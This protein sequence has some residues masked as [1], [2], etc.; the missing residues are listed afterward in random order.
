MA[1]R[2]NEDTSFMVNRS[3]SRL[4]LAAALLLAP[5]LTPGVLAQGG[6]TAPSRYEGLFG[7]ERVA[8]TSTQGLDLA[9]SIF[10]GYDDNLTAGATN[11]QPRQALLLD[12]FYSGLQSSLA[13]GKRWGTAAEFTAG[14]GSFVRHYPDLHAIT[15]MQHR[16]AVSFTAGLGSRARLNVRQ[17]V[18]YTPRYQFDPF[19]ELSGTLAPPAALAEGQ[20][21]IANNPMLVTRTVASLSQDLTSRTS[22]DATYGIRDAELR[23]TGR[24]FRH[25]YAGF[26]FG[27][28][29]TRYATLRLGYRYT[30]AG[31]SD[32][33]AQITHAP[34]VGIAYDRPLSFSRRTSVSFGGGSAIHGSGPTIDS[35]SPRYRV[36]GFAQVTRDVGRSWVSRLAYSRGVLYLE[37]YPQPF[38]SDSVVASV[39]G[40]LSPRWDLV[41]QA[42]YVRGTPHTI[43]P[44]PDR[45]A[46]TGDVRLRVAVS[47]RVA[48]YAQGTYYVYQ[49]GD[50]VILPAGLVDTLD[51]RSIRVGV[52]VWAPL[53]R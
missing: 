36:T 17:E 42:R 37:A 51:R 4:V 21:G 6:P 1:T 35:T 26:R 18:S 3:Y 29:L 52:S 13:Y 11:R 39:Q 27:H 30:E 47:S 16:G 45:T 22:F 10:E 9:V 7:R 12:G 44:G 32:A 14:A 53:L 38:F 28:R 40:Y 25:Q 34:E 43:D 50:S 48:L 49:F 15:P 31:G 20:F 46:Y 19:S 41:A 33:P 2:R 5:G 24:T 23:A 8:P